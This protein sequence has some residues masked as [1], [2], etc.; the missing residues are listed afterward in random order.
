MPVHGLYVITPDEADTAELMR[1]VRLA[2]RG[3]AGV[4]QYRNKSADAALRLEQARS[5]RT[6][7]REFSVPLIINDEVQ[8]AQEVDADGVHLGGEDGSLGAARRLLG[9]GKVIGAS[10]YN[11]LQL[12][13]DAVAQGAD[14]V[15]FGAFFPSTVKPGAVV[16][17]PGLLQQ[18]RRELAVPLVAIGGITVRNGAQ[19]VAAGAHALAVI[20]A[21][22][23]AADV[24][25]T[26]R[27]FSG[28]GFH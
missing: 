9:S 20:S 21:L 23:A 3:G 25:E 5:L 26:A 28:L 22:F 27:Q 14:Y 16:A 19:L 10:C 17:A 13:R 11:Q 8:L 24:E 12:A 18:A 15:A 6:L 2:L 1:K 7:T 4:V